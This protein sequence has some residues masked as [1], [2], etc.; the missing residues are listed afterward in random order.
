MST[1]DNARRELTEHPV[2][3]PCCRDAEVT[4]MLWF[5]GTVDHHGVTR[6]EFDELWLAH[7]LLTL[8]GRTARTH[9]V[10]GDD[11]AY[12][13][14]ITGTSGGAGA[15]SIRDERVGR[16]PARGV[17]WCDAGS[18][19]RGAFLTRGR[20]RGTGAGVAVDLR[21]PDLRAAYVL[22]RLSEQLGV[23]AREHAEW[24]WSAV[25]VCGSD[26][27]GEL[28]AAMGTGQPAPTT[29]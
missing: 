15:L 2:P 18:L 12:R 3:F 13:V 24:G 23:P 7:R 9:L 1:T 4:G 11:G 20:V 21:C 19:W 8:A 26:R 16:W 29:A 22:C 5:G 28:L 17:R 25:T 14:S 10:V 27:V 6:V